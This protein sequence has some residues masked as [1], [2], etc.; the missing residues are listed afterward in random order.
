MY[1]SVLREQHCHFVPSFLSNKKA[2][3]KYHLSFTDHFNY[4]QNEISL[5]VDHGLTVMLPIRNGTYN[6]ANQHNIST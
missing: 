5:D 1:V 6:A 3:F 4:H 2:I